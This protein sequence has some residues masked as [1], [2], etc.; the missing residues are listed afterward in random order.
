MENKYKKLQQHKLKLVFMW[1][2][3]VGVIIFATNGIRTEDL[4][5]ALLII[6]FIS[7]LILPYYLVYIRFFGFYPILD[8]EH[9]KVRH[10]KQ[11]KHD[12][13]F[14]YSDISRVEIFTKYLKGFGTHMILWIT[15][16]DGRKHK[17]C[18]LTDFKLKDELCRDLLIKGISIYP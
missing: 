8:Q 13:D 7:I 3:C 15:F 18:L 2:T 11:S 14:R 16:K 17:V 10:I 6:L 1:L 9:L 4:W 5:I 12:K